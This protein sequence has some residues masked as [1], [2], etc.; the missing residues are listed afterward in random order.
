MA[1]PLC[2][3]CLPV[4]IPGHNEIAFDSD[5]SVSRRQ[6]SQTGGLLFLPL[7]RSY[8]IV[9][10]GGTESLCRPGWPR[11]Y[12]GLHASGIKAYEIMPAWNLFCFVCQ[13]ACIL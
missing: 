8:Y 13:Q 10:L 1:F 9:L 3:L 7:K 5:C 4:A 11:T 6:Q 2:A 12:R